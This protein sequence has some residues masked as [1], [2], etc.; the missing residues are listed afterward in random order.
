MVT[1]DDP[2]RGGFRL[3]ALGLFLL[4]AP[5]EGAEGGSEAGAA[6]LKLAWDHAGRSKW[7]PAARE[8]AAA[9]S[10]LRESEKPD[11]PEALEVLGT[12][13]LMLGR[14]AQAADHFRAGLTACEACEERHRLRHLL[15]SAYRNLG[16]Y[17]AAE[18]LLKELLAEA[19]AVGSIE[20]QASSLKGLAG[21]AAV[22]SRREAALALLQ[23]AVRREDAAGKPA[24]DRVDVLEAIGVLQNE[25]GQSAQA[26]ESLRAAESLLGSRPEPSRR[27]RLRNHMAEAFAALGRSNT[28]L[29]LFDKVEEA[30]RG[31]GDD[32]E[33]SRSLCGSG[34][35]LQTEGRLAEAQSKF[36]EALAIERRLGSREGIVRAL[37]HLAQTELL[38]G[39]YN[40]AFSRFEE[41][42]ALG[43]TGA[44]R[45]TEL[46]ALAASAAIYLQMNR[47]H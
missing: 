45:E 18:S 24:A 36:E 39:Q 29:S 2:L 19:E 25:T 41:V 26:V 23:E 22:Q 32:G 31:R 14:P 42:L 5:C 7:E 35:I 37:D 28:A 27:L 40:R 8:A 16:R 12:A 34:E 17:G 46:N 11:L 30:S 33:L 47:P 3:L 13:E 15:S 4:A 44:D 1:I 20:D 43:R 6:H 21:L 10:L 38:R 9:V